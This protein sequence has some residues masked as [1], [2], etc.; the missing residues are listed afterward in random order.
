MLSLN[1]GGLQQEVH[2]VR[3][4]KLY[5]C[6]VHVHMHTIYFMIMYYYKVFVHEIQLRDFSYFGLFSYYHYQF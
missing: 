5:T 1:R 2:K 4:E 3:G 6:H